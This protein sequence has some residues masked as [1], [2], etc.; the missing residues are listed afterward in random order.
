[1]K[2]ILAVLV[3]VTS[4]LLIVLATELSLMRRVERPGANAQN[5]NA[6]SS[7]LTQVSIQKFVGAKPAPLLRAEA[8]PNMRRVPWND[9]I[10]SM[11]VYRERVEAMKRSGSFQSLPTLQPS[12]VEG[13]MEANR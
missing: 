2:A 11:R 1:M 4:I 13:L 9:S 7:A 12:K 8:L 5:W 3:A 6:S 10:D